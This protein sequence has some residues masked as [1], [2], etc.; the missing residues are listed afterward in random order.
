VGELIRRTT[1]RL[2][3]FGHC[4]WLHHRSGAVGLGVDVLVDVPDDSKARA[5][6]FLIVVKDTGVPAASVDALAEPVT[7]NRLAHRTA[8]LVLFATTVAAVVGI[9]L[10]RLESMQA[11]IY[12][13][14]DLVFKYVNNVNAGRWPTSF[15]LSAGP[16]YPYLA[17]PIVRLVGNDYSGLK[18][19]S[20][21]VSLAIL[22]STFAFSRRLMGKYF[23]LLVTFIAGM[24]SWLLVFSRLGNS[25]IAVPLLTM[26]D[27]WLIVRIVQCGKKRDI[28]WVALTSTCGMF[29][30]PQTFIEPA[31]VMLTLA[32][33]RISGHQL[34]RRWVRYFSAG[35]LPGIVSFVLAFPS[36]KSSFESYL[37]TKAEVGN[38]AGAL[39]T[40]ARNIVHA[41][42]AFHVRGD[43][44]FRSNPR[45]LPHL[46]RLSGIF[47]LL[48][49]IWW[50]G[51]AR[52]RWLPVW[53]VPF[54]LDQVPSVLV[55]SQPGEVPSASRT[56]GVAPIAYFLVASGIWMSA[57]VIRRTA[58]SRL[59]N[60]VVAISLSVLGGL[61][62]QRYFSTYMSGLPYNNTPVGHLL[63][64]YLNLLPEQTQV[65][66]VGCCWVNGLPD[67]F[68]HYELR[69]PKNLHYVEPASI[70]CEGF[71]KIAKPALFIWRTDANLPAPQ[72]VDCQNKFDPQLFVR[73]SHPLF[74]AS[75]LRDPAVST[76]LQPP[77]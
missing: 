1:D 36:N 18:L 54:I 59:A 6:Q 11:E 57:G 53:L 64:G 24:S 12:G 69:Y 21:M 67:G 43:E 32:C 26:V 68:V 74:N 41:A 31:V 7:A 30:Y 51:A 8:F 39:A 27:L 60:T 38:H 2:R 20:V 58:G 62:G 9:R 40:L 73:G 71:Q 13:D 33:L 17:A 35:L 46:D 25:Q 48:G 16:F 45:F 76:V 4:H 10:Y 50:M 63:A 37:G 14:I 34:P 22:L 65:Y 47:F 70:N 66:M 28:I 61:N 29:L 55:L 15:V 49:A 42:L 52:R 23:A 19:A 72:L 75:A 77:N 5:E 3:R 44:V 56:L